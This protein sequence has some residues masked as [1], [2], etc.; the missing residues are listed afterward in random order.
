VTSE[1]EDEY[2]DK[3]IVEA[4]R[5]APT[6]YTVCGATITQPVIRGMS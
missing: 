5:M 1:Q 6:K 3:A 4:P 2:I